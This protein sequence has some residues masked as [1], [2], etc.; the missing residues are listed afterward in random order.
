MRTTWLASD[1]GVMCA[2]CR[3]RGAWRRA[4]LV[5]AA[6]LVGLAAAVGSGC[7]AGPSLTDRRE[8]AGALRDST[9]HLR[10]SWSVYRRA[11]VP[12]P[13]YDAAGAAGVAIL[14]DQVEAGL[15]EVEKTAAKLAEVEAEVEDGR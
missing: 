3:S 8:A 5:L 9:A 14:G 1:S 6:A 11:V 13:Q 15:I 4:A 10:A 7:C 2:R 12:H